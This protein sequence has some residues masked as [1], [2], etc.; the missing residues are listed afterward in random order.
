MRGQFNVPMGKKL[1]EY[2][3]K[4]DLFRCSALLKNI[5]L[6]AGDFAKT[7][8]HVK[9]GNFVYL[10]PPYAVNSRRIFRQY[11]KHIFGTS[12]M[13]RFTDCLIEIEKSNADFLVSYADCREAR[14]IARRW[15]SIRLPVRRNIAGFA[16]A[17][18][19]AYE[20]LI[21][22]LP[23]NRIPDLEACQR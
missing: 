14:L 13:P 4:S 6:V 21:T 15:N 7:I 5:K 12:D 2:F 19:N 18:R 20:W 23:L 17:R 9:A 10:D 11:G 3:T 8:E 22:N 1:S 16:G